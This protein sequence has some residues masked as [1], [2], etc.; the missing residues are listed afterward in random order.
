MARSDKGMVF[1]YDWRDTFEELPANECKALLL[2]ML[3]Y[4]QSD[5]EPPKFK[6]KAAIAASFI[7][8]FLKRSKQN[9]RAGKKGMGKRYDAESVNNDVNNAVI[10]A[11]G[12][13]DQDINQDKN[14]DINQDINN[15]VVANE[16]S[17][18]KRFDEFWESYPR[19]V[20]K[21]SARKAWD[22]V[23]PDDELC[24][25]ILSA[26]DAQKKSVQWRKDD[27]QYIPNP[28][29]WLSQKR[30]EDELPVKAQSSQDGSFSTDEFFAAALRRTLGGTT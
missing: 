30:W 26:I 19:K 5:T 13:Q 4:C 2:A 3:D 8:S 20:G 23:S 12:N 7:F 15:A 14:Q 24:D 25:T 29:T 10:T 28:A 16:S 6:G 18:G 9:A 17:T 21:D 1:F 27:G 11:L 22:K